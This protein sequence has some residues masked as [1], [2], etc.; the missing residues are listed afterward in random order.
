MGWLPKEGELGGGG[1]DVAWGW[2]TAVLWWKTRGDPFERG[3]Y[4]K[5]E[6]IV[7]GGAGGRREASKVVGRAWDGRRRKG[8]SVVVVRWCRDCVQWCY[9]GEMEIHSGEGV[10]GRRGLPPGQGGSMMVWVHGV[11]ASMRLG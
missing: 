2:C 8:S 4:E 1:G 5:N 10:T 6:A 7:G 11:V 3:S 9:G